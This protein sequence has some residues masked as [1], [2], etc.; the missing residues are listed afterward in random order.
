MDLFIV[1]YGDIF[2]ENIHAT[3]AQNKGEIIYDHTISC[4]FRFDFIGMLW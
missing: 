3:K 4:V 1:F 2:V